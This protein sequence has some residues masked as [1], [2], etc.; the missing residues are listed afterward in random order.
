MVKREYIPHPPN[1]TPTFQKPWAEVIEKER[2]RK[3]IDYHGKI[4]FYT[5]LKLNQNNDAWIEFEAYFIYGK[6]DKILL[7]TFEKTES[8]E[9]T[10]NEWEKKKQEEEKKPWHQFKKR[11]RPFG[12]NWFWRKTALFLGKTSQTLASAQ[13]SIYKKML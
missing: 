3:K 6:L 10:L 9:K 11:L 5:N 7:K 12:W 13:T 8:R 4:E 2:Y 1:Q